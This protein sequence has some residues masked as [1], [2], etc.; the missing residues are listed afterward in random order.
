MLLTECLVMC[1]LV[2]LPCVIAIAHGPEQGAFLYE[3]DVQERVVELGLLSEAKLRRNRRLFY[4]GMLLPLLSFAIFAVYGINGARGFL[5]PFWQLTVL[6]CSEGL[7][8]RLFIDAWW[9]EHTEA[10]RIPGTEDLMPYIPREAKSR[11][12]VSTL[13][14]GPILAAVLSLT[15]LLF[16]P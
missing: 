6:I 15:M 1:F 14:S 9:V 4:L 10:W 5:G 7:F 3:K 13:L 2:L 16:F 11:K 12:W 8:D